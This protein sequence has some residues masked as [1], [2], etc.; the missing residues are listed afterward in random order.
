[1]LHTIKRKSM[2]SVNKRVKVRMIEIVSVR[3][4]FSGICFIACIAFKQ[5]IIGKIAPKSIKLKN[6][7]RPL[8]P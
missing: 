6:Q 7:R 8:G 5:N 3:D 1:M 4:L 2:A